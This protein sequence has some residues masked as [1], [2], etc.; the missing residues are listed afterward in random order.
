[1]AESKFSKVDVRVKVFGLKVVTK[2]TKGF[3]LARVH[4]YRLNGLAKVPA[5]PSWCD[6]KF[7]KA[8]VVAPCSPTLD[9]PS[10]YPVF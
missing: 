4:Q 10:P 9:E 8:L 5:D 7:L 1:M 2:F 6:L 3:W